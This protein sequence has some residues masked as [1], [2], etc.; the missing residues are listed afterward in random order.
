M[1]VDSRLHDRAGRAVTNFQRTLP[2]TDSDLAEK[3]LE[4][5]AAWETQLVERLPDD[6][7]GSLPTV[8]ELERELA[9]PTEPATD[10]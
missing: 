5:V 7:R 3:T 6:L 1:Q 2:R 4:G 8:E 9:E 10:G